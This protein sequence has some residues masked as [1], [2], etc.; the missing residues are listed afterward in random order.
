MCRYF[1][2]SSFSRP[3]TQSLTARQQG[4]HVHIYKDLRK[5]LGRPGTPL[6]LPYGTPRV[7]YSEDGPVEVYAKLQAKVKPHADDKADVK[8]DI[9]I[10]EYL[11][12]TNFSSY[13]HEPLVEEGN[14]MSSLES[15]L[16]SVTQE[17]RE[18]SIPFQ[19]SEWSEFKATLKRPRIQ[20]P[21]QTLLLYLLY[22][23][24][25]LDD[26]IAL[27]ISCDETFLL[28]HSSSWWKEYRIPQHTQL[29]DRMVE[30]IIE[31]AK[32][33]TR[34][35][36]EEFDNL[37]VRMPEAQVFLHQRIIGR[38]LGYLAVESVENYLFWR[39]AGEQPHM[40]VKSGALMR[41]G[42]F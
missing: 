36:E 14:D 16:A 26:T 21:G 27:L 6:A 15:L 20:Y 24:F 3:R 30:K 23:G 39:L 33:P 8:E 9:E 28:K 25:S 34:W 5:V 13:Y 31:V 7:A 1:F 12:G 40:D 11:Q 38:K 17:D 2:W 37:G 10:H 42:E 4:E 41:R 18:K 22:A 19:S 29:N 35:W 32:S